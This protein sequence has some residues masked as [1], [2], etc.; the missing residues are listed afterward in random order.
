MLGGFISGARMGPYTEKTES[1]KPELQSPII[2]LQSTMSKLLDVSKEEISTILEKL[3][4]R[5]SLSGQYKLKIDMK[6][7][8]SHD[9]VPTEN[10]VAYIEGTDKKDELI[11]IEAHYDHLG[12]NKKD[13]YNGADDNASGTVAIIEMAEAFAKAKEDGNGPR[14]SIL[15]MPVT[16]EEKGLLGSAYYANNPIFPLEN[17]VLTI[18]MDMIGRTDKSHIDNSDYVYVYCSDKEES[19]LH[20]LMLDAEKSVPS[21]LS[22]EYKFKGTSRGSGGSDHMSFEAKNV[23]VLYYYCG[24]HEDYHKPSDTVEKI[25]YKNFTNITRLIFSTAWELANRDDVNINR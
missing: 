21:E 10:V 1:G 11:I 18:N 12:K 19:D 20:S 23:P 13:I 22:P 7:E 2:M 17:T 9:I 15:F 24:I 3:N 6:A 16:G 8:Y 4:N 14:R 5:E 25:N